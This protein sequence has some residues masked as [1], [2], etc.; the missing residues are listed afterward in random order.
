MGKE[1]PFRY[2]LRPHHLTNLLEYSKNP[3]S[4]SL[5]GVTFWEVKTYGEESILGTELIFDDVLK[6]R[7]GLEFVLDFDNIC[8]PYCTSRRCKGCVACDGEKEV[9][10]LHKDILRIDR[11]VMEKYNLQEGV[12]YPPKKIKSVLGI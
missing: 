1:E 4:N 12:Y 8:L 6:E 10:T 3:S 5:D 9:I 11:A 7:A 2:I